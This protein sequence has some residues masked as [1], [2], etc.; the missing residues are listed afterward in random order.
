MNVNLCWIDHSFLD[1]PLKN[2]LKKIASLSV[3]Y[4]S[5]YGM[6]IDS[7]KRSFMPQHEKT[8]NNINIYTSFE[9]RLLALFR[10]WN[11]IYY[12]YPQK[13]LMDKSWDKTIA[14]SIFP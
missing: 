12:F 14:A 9:Y 3:K 5:Y 8:Y 11:V 1:E 7:V 6:N 10:Y 2:E 4:P 13:Y